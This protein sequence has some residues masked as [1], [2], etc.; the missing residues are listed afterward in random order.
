M[1]GGRSTAGTMTA[2]LRN[3]RTQARATGGSRAKGLRGRI[4]KATREALCTVKW[5]TLRNDCLSDTNNVTCM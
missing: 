1:V 2:E 5:S 4:R 3:G